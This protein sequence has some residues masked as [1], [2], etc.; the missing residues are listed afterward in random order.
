MHAMRNVRP[1]AVV[2]AFIGVVLLVCFAGMVL[3]QEAPEA[4]AAASSAETSEAGV[5]FLRAM[6][7][8]PVESLNKMPGMTPDVVTRIL[9]QRKTG[10]SFTSLLQFRKITKI[11]PVHMDEAL[12]P[13]LEQEEQLQ[14][15][16]QRKPVTPPSQP[17]KA[18]GRQRSGDKAAEPAAPATP[19]SPQGSGPVG[20][21]RPGFYA[22]LPGY[23]SLEKI[24][25]IK[26]K[27]FLE[28]VNREMCTCGCQGETL[29]FCLVNDPACPVV[30]ARVRK[31]YEEITGQSP[32]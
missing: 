2:R 31:I 29:A 3:A 10:K 17:G 7:A 19:G 24:D 26:K 13:Y 32:D 6:N 1:G 18:G 20:N 14:L 28:L 5:R 22:K 9:E 8:S 4:P 23:E 25:P 16:A 12:R 11:T 21:V 15:E 30:K 27:E